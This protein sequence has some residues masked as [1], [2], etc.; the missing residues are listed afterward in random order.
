M[1]IL[2]LEEQM[3]YVLFLQ[4]KKCQKRIRK[5]KKRYDLIDPQGDILQSLQSL[6]YMS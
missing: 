6:K 2:P 3:I 5:F 4:K 1:F